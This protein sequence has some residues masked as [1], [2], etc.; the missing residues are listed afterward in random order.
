[1]YQ[2]LDNILKGS[3]HQSGGPR[4]VAQIHC[5][6]LP[7][8]SIYTARL[9]GRPTWE[10][11]FLYCCQNISNELYPR[12]RFLHAQYSIVNCRHHVAQ[13]TSRTYS[14]YITETLESL[15]TYSLSSPPSLPG[16]LS[17]NSVLH[18]THAPHTPWP[19]QVLIKHKI[20]CGGSKQLHS[21]LF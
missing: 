8:K 16:V 10:R 14:S 5:A 7:L 13:Q 17:C 2:I 9:R 1:M 6:V 4:A 3:K 15:N 21:A 20:V 18:I 12:N 19:S 11:L